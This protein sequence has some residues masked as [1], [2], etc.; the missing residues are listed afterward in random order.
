MSP[1]SLAITLRRTYSVACD[2]PHAPQAPITTSPNRQ[3]NPI[4]SGQ[5]NR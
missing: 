5:C 3:T 4:A 1:T 2:P